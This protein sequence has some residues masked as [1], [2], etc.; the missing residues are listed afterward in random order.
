MPTP[1]LLQNLIRTKLAKGRLPLS[2]IPKMWGGPGNGKTCD[3]C[4]QTVTNDELLMEGPG[5]EDSRPVRFHVACL[6][7]W[8]AERR[9]FLLP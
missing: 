9:A 8:D 7:F 4:E 1:S 5:G 6:R 3:V 2:G